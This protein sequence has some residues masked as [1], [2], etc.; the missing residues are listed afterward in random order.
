MNRDDYDTYPI[1]IRAV[2]SS[3][4]KKCVAAKANEDHQEASSRED[5]SN[6]QPQQPTTEA[7]NSTL[8]DVFKRPLKARA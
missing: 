6:A 8:P 3:Y 4:I 2:L 7:D 5:P 1:W